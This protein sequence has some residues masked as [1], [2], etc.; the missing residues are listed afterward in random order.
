M[1]KNWLNLLHLLK[2]TI[3]IIKKIAHNFQNKRNYL[4]NFIDGRG[5]EI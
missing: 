5:N 1:E 3:M 2:N 4:I